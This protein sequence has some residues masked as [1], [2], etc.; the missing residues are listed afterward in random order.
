MGKLKTLF[1]FLPICVFRVAVMRNGKFKEN[2][3]GAV[4]P[5]VAW[6]SNGPTSDYLKP[7]NAALAPMPTAAVMA[8]M[9]NMTTNKTTQPITTVRMALVVSKSMA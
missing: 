5:V 7:P 2:D 4:S 3:G 9:M 6:M 8:V 1:V